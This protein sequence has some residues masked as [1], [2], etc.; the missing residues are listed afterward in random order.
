MQRSAK[1]GTYKSGKMVLFFDQKEIYLYGPDG[2]QCYWHDKDI[3][4][5]IFPTQH[6]RGG[7]IIISSAVSFQGKMGFQVIQGNQTTTDYNGMLERASLLTEGSRLRGNG[8]Q[9]GNAA[10]HNTR[11]TK[12]IFM[13]NN[14]ILLGQTACF[15]NLNPIENV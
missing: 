3:P 6:N 14:V 10:I 5:V 15:P 2:F 12:V 1:R 8:F 11:R 9:Q 4:P 7:S 13:A